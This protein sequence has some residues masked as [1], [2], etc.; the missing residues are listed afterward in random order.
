MGDILVS[1]YRDGFVT[2]YAGSVD[3]LSPNIWPRD[4]EGL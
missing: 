3:L 4:Q 1:P 2:T